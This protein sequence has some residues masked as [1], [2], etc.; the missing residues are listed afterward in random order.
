MFTTFTC[1]RFL[2]ESPRWLLS[3]GRREE[4]WKI[5]KRFSKKSEMSKLIMLGAKNSP[6]EKSDFPEVIR[7]YKMKLIIL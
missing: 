5:V 4:A 1:S 7:T 3:Q 2:P 6:V